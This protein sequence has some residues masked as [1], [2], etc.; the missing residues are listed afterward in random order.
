MSECGAGAEVMTMI[1]TVIRTTTRELSIPTIVVAQ[2]PRWWLCQAYLA[3][4]WLVVLANDG[5]TEITSKPTTAGGL[6]SLSL[7]RVILGYLRPGHYCNYHG[8]LSDIRR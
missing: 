5:E 1:R 4:K 2:I 7:S 3:Y 6:L 8:V